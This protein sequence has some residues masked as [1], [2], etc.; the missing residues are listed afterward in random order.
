MKINIQTGDFIITENPDSPIILMV[1]NLFENNV[2]NVSF[3]FIDNNINFKYKSGNILNIEI[4]DFKLSEKLNSIEKIMIIEID[5]EE[6]DIKNIYL[7]K[8]KPA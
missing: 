6:G 3:N 1:F 4:K 7:A 8:K 5:E 2:S